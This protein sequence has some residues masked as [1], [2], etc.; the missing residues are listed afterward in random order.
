MK[1]LKHK[2]L[3]SAVIFICIPVLM[4]LK[5]YLLG[6][7]PGDADM[8]Q[9][10]SAQK[11]FASDLLRG[12]FVQWN[13]YIAGGMPQAGSVSFYSVAL[14]LSFLPLKEFI[15]A[16]LCLHLFIG[17]FFF[18]KYLRECD[19]SYEV[20]LVFGIIYE[21]SI[22]IN[23]LR[24]SH[25]TVIAAICLLPVIM[26]FVCKFFKTKKSKWL[27]LSAL[28]AGIQFTIGTQYSI[29][30]DIFLFIY[31]VAKGIQDKFS[32]KEM[33]GKGIAW[34]FIYI[35]VSAYAIF[36][37]LAL[38]REYSEFGSSSTSYDTFATGSMHPVKILQMFLPY[39]FREIYQSYGINNSSEM[40]VEIY[41]GT[42]ILVLLVYTIWKR[43][44]TAVIELICMAGAFA[45]AGIA[46][47]PIVNKLVHKIP[48]LGG[49]RCSGRMLF[50][51]VFMGLTLAAKTL[52]EVLDKQKTS[53][54][55]QAFSDMYKIILILL[56]IVTVAMIT[57]LIC[58]SYFNV[59]EDNIALAKRVFGKTFFVLLICIVA[60]NIILKY[61]YKKSFVLCMV[62][63]IT[64]FEVLPFSLITT[65]TSYEDAL[66]KE[67]IVQSL[68]GQ[69]GEYKIWDAF[70]SVDGGH[71]SI[72]SQNRSAILK[73]P[74]I[75]SYTAYN[76]PNLCRYLK[77]LGAGIVN[78]PFNFSG[79]NT[80]S[81]Y[82]REILV[83][84]ND[85]LSMLGVRYIIDSSG[86][87]EE[88]LEDGVIGESEYIYF[89]SDKNGTKIYENV[90]ACDI[91]F[92]PKEIHGVDNFEELYK[93]KQNYDLVKTAYIDKPCE[94][95][96]FIP[97]EISEK[98]FE[99]DILTAE[100]YAKEDS[101]LCF[102][103]NYSKKWKAYVDGQE[104]EIA[105][106][107]GVIMGINLESG[108]HII[109]FVYFDNIYI[110]GGIVSLI[111]ILSLV[112]YCI[113]ISRSKALQR[114][115]EKDD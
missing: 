70:N 67:D 61:K 9:F 107:D 79:L 34:I 7:I 27:Y 85:L 84:E 51:F 72:I 18:Y 114:K 24:K 69:I 106:V 63:L 8:I 17:S 19:C 11:S 42:I 112:G 62:L 90:N 59:Q 74:S 104:V 77:N 109:Q 115:E 64:L 73:L 81:V 13:K 50:V 49:F 56:K 58:G 65:P 21:C 105:F 75:N 41:L 80:G 108:H 57:F 47:L 52:S 45:Y 15:Y 35:G 26:Y 111:T 14:L 99:G 29:Y 76:N 1:K 95:R 53:D 97:V 87:I 16:Y 66:V 96:Q 38:M 94:D 48:V 40:D 36:P 100:V 20:A 37:S 92:T 88:N 91:L 25:P 98:K 68:S 93:N 2:E 54:R 22:Q 39:S 43:Y 60:Y 83:N 4:Y 55:K 86:L 82:A 110:I 31:I 23:G 89:G 71:Q 32:I 44:K 33:I 102:S 5:Q 46:H 101:F 103:Q 6:N 10:F 12:S 113:I 30:A 28:M 3:V 78:I